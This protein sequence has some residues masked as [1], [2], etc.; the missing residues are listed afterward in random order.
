VSALIRR[1]ADDHAIEIVMGWAAAYTYGSRQ[2]RREHR[3]HRTGAARSFGRSAAS[4]T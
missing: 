2:D 4:N 3:V 1:A